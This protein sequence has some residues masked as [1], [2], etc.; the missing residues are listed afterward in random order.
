MNLSCWFSVNTLTDNSSRSNS[1]R[2]ILV[3][4]D[5]PHDLFLLAEAI[6]AEKLNMEIDS[7]VD[8]DELFN[9]LT[10]LGENAREAYG[11]VVLDYH[12]PRRSAEE[13]L[14]A[15]NQQQRNLGIPLVVMTTAISEGDKRRLLKLGVREILSK[16]FD[17]SE[18][19]V[20]ALTLSSFLA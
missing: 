2:R 12:L 16:P 3:A 5:N 11:L 18:Y 1:N 6:I 4:E 7:V 9:R 8:G 19:S 14:M 13:V 17:L 10:T 20:L 15:L